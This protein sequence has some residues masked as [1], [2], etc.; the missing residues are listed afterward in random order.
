MTRR[1]KP[2]PDAVDLDA[3]QDHP[4]PQGSF[5]AWC[6]TQDTVWGNILVELEGTDSET[7]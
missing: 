1:R 5:D 6:G 4:E 2:P 7:G 3:V